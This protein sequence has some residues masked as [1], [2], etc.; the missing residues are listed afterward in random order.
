M[1]TPGWDFRLSVT[2]E[3]R[4]LVGH[5]GAILLRRY[6]DW[7]RLTTTLG[8]AFNRCAAR[9]DRLPGW[10][11]S[12]A[13]VQ[14]AIAIVLGARSMRQIALL[15][16]Q[17]PLFSAPL[18][19]STIR[20]VLAATA[21]DRLTA[22]INRA[23]AATRAQTRDL[24]AAREPGFPW[25]SA[26]GQDVD[27]LD[28]PGHGRRVDHRALTQAGR[29]P[30][31]QEGLLVPLAGDLMRQHRQVAGDPATVGQRRR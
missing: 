29:R 6:V 27:G 15:S 5:T 9:R 24:L 1:K 4:G 20:R 17:A 10:D 13:L 7:V 11:C 2:A 22:A 25:V 8:R 21:D 14:P 3:G 28:G 26:G 30:H 19:D 12:I 23:R 31:L 18:S 16:H